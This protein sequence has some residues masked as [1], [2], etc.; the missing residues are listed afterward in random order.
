M[1]RI[2]I[3]QAPQLSIM[4]EGFKKVLFCFLQSTHLI[5]VLYRLFIY[6]VFAVVFVFFFFFWFLFCF[7]VFLELTKNDVGPQGKYLKTVST[8][9]HFDVHGGPENIPTNRL[10]FGKRKILFLYLFAFLSFFNFLYFL[11][12]FLLFNFI[13][14]F[15]TILCH[16]CCCINKRLGHYVSTG[17]RSVC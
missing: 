14:F 9:K 8:C 4:C 1:E 11:F 13:T 10:T 12:L 5:Y 3:L 17:F 2:H 7:V 16:R 6:I 15:F